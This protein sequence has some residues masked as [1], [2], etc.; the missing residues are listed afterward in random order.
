MSHSRHQR[1]ISIRV[2][3]PTTS[4]KPEAPLRGT[5]GSQIHSQPL[6]TPFGVGDPSRAFEPR[7]PQSTRSPPS[8]RGRRRNR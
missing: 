4:I 2:T 5:G 8:D 7:S 1:P 3:L 6:A